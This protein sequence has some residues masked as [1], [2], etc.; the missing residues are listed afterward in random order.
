MGQKETEQTKYRTLLVHMTMWLVVSALLVACG[1]GGGGGSG[2]EGE[3][4]QVSDEGSGQLRFIDN[5]GPL[6]ILAVGDSITVGEA[7]SMSYRYWLYHMLLAEGLDVDFIGTRSGVFGGSPRLWDY[8]QDHEAYAGGHAEEVNGILRTH[9]GVL[10]PQIALVHIGTNDMFHDQGIQGTVD[11][12]DGIIFSLRLL[13]PEVRI[14]LAQIIP[15]SKKGYQIAEF[16]ALLPF[17]AAERSTEE[18]PV[19]IVDQ[20]SGF[21]P[22]GDTYDGTHPNDQGD[23]KIAER[24]LAAILSL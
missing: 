20:W 11:E 18:S 22:Y 10:S 9:I 13:N 1:G 17:L 19:V 3:A 6:R 14:L 23:M 8:D 15:A 4:E 5:D 21:D 24:W 16:N 2:G 7:P 12:V